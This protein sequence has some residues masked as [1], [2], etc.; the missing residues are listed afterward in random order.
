MCEKGFFTCAWQRAEQ[1]TTLMADWMVAKIGYCKRDFEE[2][3]EEPKS[4]AQLDIWIFT[5]WTPYSGM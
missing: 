1:Y 5:L 2:C 4:L 3:L